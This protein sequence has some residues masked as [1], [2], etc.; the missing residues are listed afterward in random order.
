[1]SGGNQRKDMYLMFFLF[2]VHPFEDP[3]F[4]TNLDC[5]RNFIAFNLHL[6]PFIHNKRPRCMNHYTWK[7]IGKYLQPWKILI[8]LC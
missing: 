2:L 8:K 5:A 4:N 1:M 3:S 7:E 6:N